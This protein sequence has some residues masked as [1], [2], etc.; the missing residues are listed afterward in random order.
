MVYENQASKTLLDGVYLLK[1]C[2]RQDKHCTYKIVTNSL[3][4]KYYM[5]IN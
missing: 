4:Q 5:S 1:T 2:I 3:V